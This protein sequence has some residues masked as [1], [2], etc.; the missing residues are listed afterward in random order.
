MEAPDSNAQIFAGSSK[1]NPIELG[2]AKRASLL[3]TEDNLEWKIEAPAPQRQDQ[4]F[5]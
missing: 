5:L 1:K 4:E 3:Q 2:R